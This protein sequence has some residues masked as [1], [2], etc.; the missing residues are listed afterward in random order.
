MYYLD[1]RRIHFFYLI[2]DI[3]LVGIS[4]YLPYKY[5]P[6]L[7]AQNSLG[8]KS[9]FSVFAIW[10]LSIV[11]LLNNFHLYS[12]DRSLSISEEWRLVTRC[13]LFSSILAALFIFALKLD[14]FSRLIFM[15][16]TILLLFSLSAWRS[17]KRIYVRYLIRKGYSNDNVLIVGAGKAGVLLSE[18]IQ[19]NPY[20][21]LRIAGFLDDNNLHNVAGFKV[22]GKIEDLDYVVKKNFIDEIYITIPSERKIVSEI[23]N[24]TMKMGKTVRVLAERFD[25]PYQQ[26]GLNYIG[27]IPLITYFEK[28]LH[29][30]EQLIKRLFDIMLSSAILILLSPLFLI[31]AFLIKW[32]GPGPVFYISQRCGKQG[33]IFNF[34]KFRSMIDGADNYKEALRHKSE[35]KG[36]IFKIKNDP[37]ITRLGN[38]LRRYSLDEMPQLINVLKGDMSLIGP[39]PFP[40]EESQKLENKHLLRLS[41]KPGITGLAQIKGRSDLSFH[42]WAKWDLWYFNHWSFGLDL[43]ILWGT[44]P[45]VL[46][47]RG[48]Y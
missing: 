34:Y 46:K 31:I 13:V 28:N 24:Q 1:K 7:V 26:V 3:F 42:H 16:A 22:L 21:G 18:E 19:S 4:F 20:L 47:G 8:F 40:V 35:V 11:F 2:S 9:Y 15:E 39:R 27:F 45:A 17:A 23:L 48:A 43:K 32:E 14:F 44:I 25:R 30:T 36:P 6:A 38:F 33:R 5:N 10:G 12:T 29:G 41:I 37:R